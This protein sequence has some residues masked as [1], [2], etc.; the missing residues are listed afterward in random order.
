[1]GSVHKF[2]PPRRNGKKPRPRT[3]DAGKLRGVDQRGYIQAMLA[4]MGVSLGTLLGIA[5]WNW[6]EQAHGDDASLGSST[7]SCSSPRVIDG[8]T[9]DCDGQRIRLEGIDAP[10]LPGH[11]RQGR[12]CAPGDPFASM[13]SLERL[14]AGKTVTCKQSDMDSYGRI[15]AHCSVGAT[16]L[17]CAQLS[18]GL[19]ISRY[20]RISCQ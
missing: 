4:T 3:H 15:V 1:M 2:K 17:S 7:I 10:E 11:C 8:D 20:A 6:W 16:D 14:V 18:L 13:A 12:R 9:L 5:G 19:A